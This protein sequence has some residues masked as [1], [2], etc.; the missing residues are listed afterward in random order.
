MRPGSPHSLLFG[1]IVCSWNFVVS[2][3]TAGVGRGLFMTLCVPLPEEFIYLKY[4]LEEQV[5]GSKEALSIPSRRPQGHI[6][7]D[8]QN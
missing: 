3:A 8:W 7:A 4:A 1:Q 2:L 5:K 6:L